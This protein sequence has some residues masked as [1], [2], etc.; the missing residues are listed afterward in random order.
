VNLLRKSYAR[1]TQLAW[2]GVSFFLDFPRPDTVVTKSVGDALLDILDYHHI[3][4]IL[5]VTEPGVVAVGLHETALT[6][7][8]GQ[9]K[10]VTV[11]TETGEHPTIANVENALGRYKDTQCQAVIG[12]GGGAAIDC[13]KGVAARL[14]QPR[15]TITALCGFFRVKRRKTL[16]IAVPTTAGP[17]S[18]ATA[19]TVIADSSTQEKFAITDQRLIPEFTVLDVNLTLKITPQATA[20]AGMSALALAVEAFIGQANT[21]TTKAA[22]LK[23]VRLTMANL[24]KAYVQPD[25]VEA[26][27]NMQEAALEAGVAGARAGAGL[28][29]AM[30]YQLGGVYGIPHGLAS[31]I[32]LP[33]VLR[34]I[35]RPAHKKL[36]Q[37]ADVLALGNPTDSSAQ[38]AEAFIAWIS[39]L[40]DKMDIKN[41]FGHLIE[42]DRIPLLATRAFKEAYP[43]YPVPA[44]WDQKR[45]AQVYRLLQGKE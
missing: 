20:Y 45:Y 5:F 40:N 4:N 19:T 38:K 27:R 30:A 18:E 17:G 2:R 32:L 7:L 39:G 34:E 3:Q 15:K 25:D 23:A 22:A 1:A 29:H 16:L 41:S 31:A 42:T 11:Y 37:L 9:D 14:A 43:F 12:F 33:L 35:G 6:R 8:Y 13:A 21:K 36:A 44:M 10:H 24:L 28:V 26:R